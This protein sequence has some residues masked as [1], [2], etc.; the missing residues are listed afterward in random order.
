MNAFLRKLNLRKMILKKGGF[1]LVE[2][3][4]T[5][6][7]TVIV[8]AVSSTLV[9][10]GTN[11]FARSAQRDVQTN[12]AETVLSFVS[13]QLLYAY[14][15][16]VKGSTEQV[17][18]GIGINGAVLHVISPSDNR[19]SDRG[20]LY[21]RRDGDT[22]QPINIFGENFYS[23]YTIG[24]DINIV[25]KSGQNNAYFT[26][27]VNVYNSTGRLA[28]SRSTTKP[29]L[30]YLPDEPKQIPMPGDIGRVIDITLKKPEA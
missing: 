30:N 22:Q 28:L 27:T 19:G 9:I 1:T 4:V 3:M 18:T 6:I 25:P 16:E 20:H 12:I 24:L 29:L 2:V 26:L 15:V 23:G 10:T 13:D 14:L 21:F 8:I 17:Y 11:I 7:I 5:L